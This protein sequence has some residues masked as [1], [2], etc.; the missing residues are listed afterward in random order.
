LRAK[1]T[2][3]L[4]CTLG[5]HKAQWPALGTFDRQ[6]SR[7][8][9][10]GCD[11]VRRRGG[12]WHRPRGFRIVWPTGDAALPRPAEPEAVE[13][14]ELFPWL[15]DPADPERRPPATRS[16]K[17]W[18]SA[19]FGARAAIPLPD[20]SPRTP[21]PPEAHEAPTSLPW[22]ATPPEPEEDAGGAAAKTRSSRAAHGESV[23]GDF[24]GGE[25]EDEFDWQAHIGLKGK[26]GPAYDKPGEPSGRRLNP[27]R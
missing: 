11:L 22:Q 18:T 19:W 16:R 25:S 13:I 3:F 26:D 27:R 14:P 2:I 9:R 8:A 20:L 21:P 5:R 15:A 6:F 10:C 4:L 12:A 17:V 23:G 24:M 1:L 7:C